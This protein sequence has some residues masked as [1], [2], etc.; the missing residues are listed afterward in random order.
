MACNIRHIVGV[1]YKRS[2]LDIHTDKV[3]NGSEESKKEAATS[4]TINMIRIIQN[5]LSSQNSLLV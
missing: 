5:Y 1:S 3:E 4:I 2:E